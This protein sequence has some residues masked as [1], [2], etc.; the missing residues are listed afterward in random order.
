[1]S[2]HDVTHE[3]L[4][5]IVAAFNARD[6]ETIVGFFAEDGEMLLAA[7]P[8]NFGMRL[9]G[10]DELRD[11]LS[12]RFAAVPDIQWGEGSSWISG[13][14]AVSEWRVTG[15]LPDGKKLDCLGCDLWLFRAGKIVKK[16]TYYKQVTG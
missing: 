4:D 1:M 13:N 10:K 15:T 8:D 5:E 16:D 3:L 2:D 12:Q 7:G 6:V 11:G 14:R 9:K